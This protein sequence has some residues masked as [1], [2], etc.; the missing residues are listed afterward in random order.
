METATQS[1]PEGGSKGFLQ[2]LSL[3]RKDRERL[4]QQR[5]ERVS[6]L[7][8]RFCVC[9]GNVK[10]TSEYVSD[11]PLD[12]V[13]LGGKNPLR[14]QLSC[15]CLGCGKKDWNLYAPP[16]RTRLFDYRNRIRD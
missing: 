13:K 10:Y 12:E 1:V 9:G 3:I 15:V 5:I 8:T 16:F 14:E 7:F 11:V 6:L 2:Y 4:A